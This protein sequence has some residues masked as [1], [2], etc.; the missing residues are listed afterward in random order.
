[1]DH[2]RFERM[3]EAFA[4]A[5]RLV[6]GT[7][8]AP[9][10]QPVKLSAIEG[11][12][13]GVHMAIVPPENEAPYSS[14]HESLCGIGNNYMLD[15]YWRKTTDAADCAECVGKADELYDEGAELFD[16]ALYRPSGWYTGPPMPVYE[17]CQ[18][19]S[20]DGMMDLP[21]ITLRKDEDDDEVR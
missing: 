1:M 8:T 5:A 3:R 9:R 20:T 13:D 12:A 11:R 16:P 18:I 21:S 7:S 14:V 2:E 15:W 17:F 4:Q 19:E 10:S 6:E